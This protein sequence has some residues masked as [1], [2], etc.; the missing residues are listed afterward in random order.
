MRKSDI[1]KDDK[2]KVSMKNELS[3]AVIKDTTV[4]DLNL[5]ISLIQAM[6]ARKQDEL[7]LSYEEVFQMSDY[8]NLSSAQLEKFVDDFFKKVS[9]PLNVIYIENETGHEIAAQFLPFQ[10]IKINKTEHTIKIHAG[11]MFYKIIT[12][13]D[14]KYM[15]F[16]KKQF[17]SLSTTY[18]KELFLLLTRNKGLGRRHISKDML[19]EKLGVDK[20]C[21]QKRFNQQILMPTIERLNNGYF[22]NL[23]V[24]KI[25]TGRKISEYV[26]QFDKLGKDGE[27][28]LT[29]KRQ[30]K[31]QL[32]EFGNTK[33]TRSQAVQLI[34]DDEATPGAFSPNLELT[35]EEVAVILTKGGNIIN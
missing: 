21:P 34:C 17:I 15:S 19:Y 9:N 7:L 24:E 12:E 27:V 20:N 35:N 23:T 33:L 5:Y 2:T 8:Y 16:S 22:S 30:E 6:R 29:K 10:D 26:F 25:R 31:N 18:S 32:Y 11:D 1:Q 3:S 14:Q 13:T 28:L 4:K